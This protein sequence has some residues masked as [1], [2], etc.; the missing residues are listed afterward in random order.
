MVGGKK[1]RKNG[2]KRTPLPFFCWSAGRIQPLLFLNRLLP[3]TPPCQ[4]TKC[5]LYSFKQRTPS[6]HTDK[7]GQVQSFSFFNKM[8]AAIIWQ[9]SL[10]F[11]QFLEYD[12]ACW[13]N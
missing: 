6:I 10:L 4:N 2:R 12:I 8:V 11:H 3:T 7:G 13:V 1:R 9:S 5:N